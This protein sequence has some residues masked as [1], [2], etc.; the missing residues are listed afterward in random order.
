M[1][2][3]RQ[4]VWIV[5]GL[6]AVAIVALGI[7]G[8]F[9]AS[10]QV[11]SALGTAC[12]LLVPAAADALGVESRRRVPGAKAVEDDIDPEGDSVGGAIR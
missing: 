4:R 6:A 11:L 7:A 9:G 8:A 2:S 10:A 3:H 5:C 12:G 1:K